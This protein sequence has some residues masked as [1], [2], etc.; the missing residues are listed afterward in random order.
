MPGWEIPG[1]S[2]SLRLKSNTGWQRK[3][4]HGTP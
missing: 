3:Q 2:A 4:R 1:N